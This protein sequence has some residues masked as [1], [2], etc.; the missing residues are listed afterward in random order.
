MAWHLLPIFMPCGVIPFSFCFAPHNQHRSQ[1]APIEHQNTASFASSRSP[2]RS[3][4]LTY[5]L[6]RR[7][8]AAWRL[9]DS[10][11][12]ARRVWLLIIQKW[13]A[14][15]GT[16]VC[17]SGRA[18]PLWQLRAPVSPWPISWPCCPREAWWSSLLM[19]VAL[20]NRRTEFRKR[21]GCWMTPCTSLC[22]AAF[23]RQSLVSL[24][25]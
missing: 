1:P 21:R 22:L 4:V 18:A 13:L 16:Q 11:S 20:H 7:P 6:L 3:S 12:G 8:D 24:Q 19:P 17:S 9:Q 23:P 5:P 14:P 2:L 25:S 15:L 10:R